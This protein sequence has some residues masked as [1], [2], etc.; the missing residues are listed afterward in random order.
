MLW[1]VDSPMSIETDASIDANGVVYFASDIKP[2]LYAVNGTTGGVPA[3]AAHPMCGLTSRV[4]SGD[5]LWRMNV[6][7]PC[8]KSQ[9][10]GTSSPV[11]VPGGILIGV[12]GDMQMVAPSPA[13][14]PTTGG[15]PPAKWCDGH[16]D[17]DGSHSGSGSGSGS[18]DGGNGNHDGGGHGDTVW[19]VLAGVLV[20][21]FAVGAIAVVWFRHYRVA[22]TGGVSHVRLVADMDGVAS[23]S[24]DDQH[25]GAAMVAL[26]PMSTGARTPH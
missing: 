5:I 21:S 3:A 4:V 23:T 8:K 7:S 25:R 10:W 1:Q 16:G 26:R 2:R 18:G 15:V 13:T 14:V 6:T 19:L 20:G 22:D 17:N 9:C 24:G 11:V 12:N